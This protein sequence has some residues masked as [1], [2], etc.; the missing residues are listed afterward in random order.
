LKPSST[1]TLFLLLVLLAMLVGEF[2]RHSP[3]AVPKGTEESPVGAAEMDPAFTR[4]LPHE[5]AMLPVAVR[6]D[7]PMGSETGALTY[8]AQPFRMTRHLGDD[9]NGIG[10][11]NS[12]LGDPVWAAADGRVVFCGEAAKGWGKMVILACRVQE[13]DSAEWQVL[14]AV[15]AHLQEV[16]V[17]P[18]QLLQRGQRL[19]TVGTGGGLYYAHLHF[20]LRRGPWVNP[21][22]GYADAG[23]N[24]FSPEGFIAASKKARP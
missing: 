14:Q 4:L 15:Y 2:L 16:E 11:Y 7:M 8:N 17:Q 19:G 23:L 22:I 24:R 9:L 1:I 13:P 20:E 10:G 12:D 21:G 3:Q 18:G 6:W 5:I